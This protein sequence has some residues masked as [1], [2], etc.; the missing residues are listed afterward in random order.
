[1]INNTVDFDYAINQ[2]LKE[3]NTTVY[4][5][6]DV[7]RS[8]YINNT[9]QEIE[10]TLNTLYEK[11]RYLEDAIAY[12]KKF[13]G[14]RIDHFNNEINSVLH[15]IENIAD[16]SKNLSYI[17]YNVPFVEN[18]KILTDRDG[19]TNLYPLVVK[20]K[21]LT[22]DYKS[23]NTQEF[24]GIF[25]RVADFIPFNDNL[26]D[27]MVEKHVSN[28]L[29]YR[30]LYL[31]EKI[32]PD[33]LSETLIVCFKEP[34]IINT[35]D[36][37]P[38]NC[39]IQN[40][41]FGLINGTEEYVGDYKTSM[42][43]ETRVCTYIK[44]DLV[45]SSYDYNS[46]TLDKKYMIG[47]VWSKLK[48]YEYA[49]YTGILK[50]KFDLWENDVWRN[51][52]WKNADGSEIDYYVNLSHEDTMESIQSM[53][54]D[55][56]TINSQTGE[57]TTEK[58]SAIDNKQTATMK[59]YSYIFGIDS[60]NVG[61]YEFHT[62]GY[63]I[64]DPIFIGNLKEG[65]FIRLDVKDTR[66]DNCEIS[67]S[68][69]D[70][71]REIP[72]SI[73][74]DDWINNELIFNNADTRFAMDYDTGESYEGEIIKR[75]GKVVGI[76]YVDAKEQAA[77]GIGRYTVS[78]KPGLDYYD[79]KPL[80]NTIQIKCYIRTYGKVSNMPSISSIRIKKYGEES[81]WINR[82]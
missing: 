74:K 68:I 52:N 22:L 17:S 82:Y 9:F 37:K 26:Y 54:I 70:G 71:D 65:E 67:Y 73:M 38:V 62:D 12:T 40:L 4:M 21:D 29:P 69:L 32:I 11:T 60:F 57:K 36:I 45:C 41:K 58:Y 27:V 10:T 33:G 18:T 81:L 34:T 31:E 72:V 43:I 75:D 78:Y 55:K 3:T 6:P 63:M 1:M 77:L 20:N 46:Y 14:T 13:L 24:Y 28:G 42:T 80:N 61:N 64:S 5:Q 76:S 30:S 53:I 56:T 39:T 23:N 19:I 66:Y 35:L 25:D 7:L 47:D 49:D 16:S 15:E 48:Y 50:N 44:F 51:T 8:D 59:M 2:I 79:Y